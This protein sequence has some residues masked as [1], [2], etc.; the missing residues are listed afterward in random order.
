MVATSIALVLPLALLTL[1]AAFRRSRVQ[2]FWVLMAVSAGISYLVRLLD[3]IWLQV[4]GI[5][6]QTAL[7]VVGVLLFSRRPGRDYQS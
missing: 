7:C 1:I 6:L 4:L 5:V 3:V 2:E